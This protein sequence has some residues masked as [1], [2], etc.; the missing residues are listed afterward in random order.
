MED[1]LDN[2]DV[3]ILPNLPAK[4]TDSTQESKNMEKTDKKYDN[5]DDIFADAINHYEEHRTS[6]NRTTQNKQTLQKPPIKTQ[7]ITSNVK[8][9]QKKKNQKPKIIM[10]DYNDYD[11]Y[12]DYDC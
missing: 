3:T 5:I 8:K 2:K 12:D 9:V 11:D 6:Q 4:I 7:P 10:D 1:E